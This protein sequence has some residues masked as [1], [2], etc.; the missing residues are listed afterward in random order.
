MEKQED[1]ISCPHCKSL[2]KK[3]ISTCPYCKKD[4][5]NIKPETDNSKPI[6]N[7]PL[8]IVK[9]VGSIALIIF[10]FFVLKSCFFS[11]SNSS[12]PTTQSE[13]SLEI[14]A[15]VRSQSVCEKYLKAP[16]T[17]KF[18]YFGDSKVSVNKI[19]DGKYSIVSYVD[20]ENSFGAMI[21]TFYSVTITSTGED[22][23]T[24]EDFNLIE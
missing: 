12:T 23:Y 3:D 10:A 11:G 7:T 21:R 19:S 16:S 13:Q 14:E 22:T 1:Y 8:L 4:I 6:K 18:P 5:N 24:Y 20:S 9:I 17:A 15:F 2:I